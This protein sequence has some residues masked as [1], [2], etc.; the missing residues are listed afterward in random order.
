M[1][2]RTAAAI[3]GDGRAIDLKEFRAVPSA[4]R[5]YAYSTPAQR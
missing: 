1:S 3:A 2:Q 4:I 5:S